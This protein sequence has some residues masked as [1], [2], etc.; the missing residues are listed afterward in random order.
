[1][2]VRT[3]ALTHSLSMA[4]IKLQLRTHTDIDLA[5]LAVRHQSAL[6]GAPGNVTFPVPQPSAVVFDQVLA[7]FQEKIRTLAAAEAA[8]RTLRLERDAARVA[9][10]AA[11]RQRAAYAESLTVGPEKLAGAGLP[12]QAERLPTSWLP[13]PEN[14]VAAIGEKE[15][16]IHLTCRAVPRAKLYIWECRESVEGTLPLPWQRV[17]SGVR[18][19]MTISGLVSGRR[20]T[21]RVRCLGPHDLESAW[22]D[23]ATSMAR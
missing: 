23:E 11:L 17:K 21:F 14:L 15:G 2:S 10:E 22:S 7:T 4:K 19:S 5:A 18:S 16:E 12:L 13:K 8:L 6:L 9:L 3:H 20:F 1:M